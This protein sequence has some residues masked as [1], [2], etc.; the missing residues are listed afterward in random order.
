MRLPTGILDGGCHN[1]SV[2]AASSNARTLSGPL[3]ALAAAYVLATIAIIA[4]SASWATTYAGAAP[5]SFVADLAAGAG[6]IGAGGLLWTER[7]DS[8]GS[9]LAGVAGVTWLAND[10]IGWQGGP[11]MVRS[12]AELAAPLTIVLILD[13]VRHVGPLASPAMLVRAGTRATYVVVGSVAVGHSLVHDPRLEATCW[14]LCTDNALLVNGSS[15]IADALGSVATLAQFA[16]AAAVVL[17][18]AGRLAGATPT[19]RRMLWPIVV[20]AA[21]FGMATMAH[22]GSLVVVPLEGPQIERYV[23]LYDLRAWSAAAVAAGMAW[24]ALRS[25]RTRA[26]LARLTADLATVPGPGSLAATL[27]QAANDPTLEVGYWLTESGRLV[28]AAGRTVEL[29]RPAE[30]RGITPVIRDGGQI[31]MVIHDPAAVSPTQLDREFGAATRLAVDNE[32]LQAELIVQ[33]TEVRASRARIVEA[34]DRERQRLERN[35]HDAAQQRLAALTYDL[36][37]ARADALVRDDDEVLAV[38]STALDQVQGAIDDLR[39]LAHGIYPTILTDG[40]LRAAVESLA[41]TTDFPLEIRELPSARFSPAV[42]RTAYGVL[43]AFVDAL[44]TDSK[45]AIAVSVT[46][47]AGAL[48]VSLE[49]EGNLPA[50]KD[51]GRVAALGGTVAAGRGRLKVEIPCA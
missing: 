21:A 22:A 5:Q 3:L 28:D 9:L 44:G 36:R 31:A 2:A 48:I 30:G 49:G 42:E 12:L 18:A 6:L 17:L 4:V 1:A 34:G 7:R 20:P 10:W 16:V 24:M 43:I 50:L 33:L 47:R 35:L 51:D 26:A 41:E 8:T 29:P 39:T 38:T 19:A 23:L 15:A 25:R 46:A 37:R 40:G 45:T 27:A 13:L 11:P 32:R 14:N